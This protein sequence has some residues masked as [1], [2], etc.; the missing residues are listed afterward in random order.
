GFYFTVSQKKQFEELLQKLSLRHKKE[1][2][3][4]MQELDLLN[5]AKQE[6]NAKRRTSQLLQKMQTLL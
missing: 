5:V 1:S 6:E 2:G 4:I 3:I